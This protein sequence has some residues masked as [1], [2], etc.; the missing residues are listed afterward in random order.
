MA[1]LR[2]VHF[3]FQFMYALQKSGFDCLKCRQFLSG[4]YQCHGQLL[5]FR[6]S[7]SLQLLLV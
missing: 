3:P 7:Q 4:V 5:F 1:T 2:M 6:Q